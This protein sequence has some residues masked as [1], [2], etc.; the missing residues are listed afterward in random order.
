MG[1]TYPPVPP[2]KKLIFRKSKK[3]PKTGKTIY[4]KTV[5]PIV[6]PAND[7]EKRQE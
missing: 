1:T 7:N 3:C 2:G 4:A 6:V 5:F